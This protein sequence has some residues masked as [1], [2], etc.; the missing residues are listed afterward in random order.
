MIDPL[1]SGLTKKQRLIAARKIS[2]YSLAICVV[3]VTLG[4]W[5]LKLFGLSLPIVQI[6]G[7][8]IIFHMGWNLLIAKNETNKGPETFTQPEDKYK[9]VENILFYPI[10]FPMLSGAGTISVLLTLSASSANQ[11]WQQYLFNTGSL[12]VGIIM[13]VI[14]IYICLINTLFLFKRIGSRGQQVVNRISAFLVMCV[15]LQILWEGIK[16]LINL[17]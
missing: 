11:N 15:G 5:V 3:S 4:S 6:A 12:I 2:F 7:G 9:E 1:L 10:S 8:I 14:L 13:M 17:Q 16:H